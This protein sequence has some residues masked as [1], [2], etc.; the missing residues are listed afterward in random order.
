MSASRKGN[1]INWTLMDEWSWDRPIMGGQGIPER[2]H[3]THRAKE[4]GKYVLCSHVQP[5]TGSRLF[6]Y[7]KD[8]SRPLNG[9][10]GFSVIRQVIPMLLGSLIVGPA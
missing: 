5:L 7:T 2:G 8:S 10:P 3:S 6:I 1:N 9:Y 4:E